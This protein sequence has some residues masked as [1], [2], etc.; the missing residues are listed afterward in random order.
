MTANGLKIQLPSLINDDQIEF[1]QVDRQ[2]RTLKQF[3]IQEYCKINKKTEIK[4]IL[5]FAK[6]FDTIEW[7]FINEF[8]IQ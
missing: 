2:T 1:M 4:I 3:I 8:M 6:A 5:D 7:D